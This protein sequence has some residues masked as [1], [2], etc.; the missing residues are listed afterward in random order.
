MTSTPGPPRLLGFVGADE[1]TKVDSS[2]RYRVAGSS[3]VFK[4]IPDRVKY[5]RVNLR[6]QVLRQNMRPDLSRYDCVLNLVTDPDQQPRTLEAVRKLLRGYRGRV[7]NRPDAVL[8]TT[9]D[10]VA[11]R[12]AGIPGLRVPKV[13]RMRN[14]KPG[15]ASEAAGRIGLRFPLIVRLAGTHTGRIIGLVHK[16]SGLDAACAGRGDFI[17]TEFVDYRSADGL[18]RK[19]RIWAFG[20]LSIFRHMAVTDEWNVH[21]GGGNRFMLDRPALIEEEGR[22]MA[23]TE[24]DFPAAVH[25][26]FAAIRDRLGLNFFGLDFA[27]DGD[28][29]MVLFEANATMNFFPLVVDPR[30]AYRQQLYA[31]AQAAFLRMLGAEAQH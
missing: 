8:R 19:Y 24:G 11:K 29:Q 21:I 2:G 15:A 14:P 12:L 4:L 25:A 1:G 30:F 31:P 22:L 27:I 9:R 10:L 3:D 20:K 17:L 18:F 7:I 28:G 13:L 23:K 26:T 16:A 5:D 6:W